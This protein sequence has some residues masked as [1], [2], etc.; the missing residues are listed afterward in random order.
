[1]R[2]GDKVAHHVEGQ[3]AINGWA[4]RLAIGVLQD[5]V[6]VGRCLRDRIGRNIAGRSRAI[7]HD[8]RLAQ[9]FGQLGPH[10]AGERVDGAPA[11]NG[12]MMRIG[13]LG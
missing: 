6:T 9:S 1:L 4:D 3:R 2:H 11:T 7:L 5:G 12:T 13:R 10:H 8:D